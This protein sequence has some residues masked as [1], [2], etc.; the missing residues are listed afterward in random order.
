M[1]FGLDSAPGELNDREMSLVIN[2][3]RIQ[4]LYCLNLARR[5][6]DP[7]AMG[8]NMVNALEFQVLSD[9]LKGNS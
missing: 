7:E 3:L 8:R 5:N 4:R 9:K 2:A 1:R 6:K